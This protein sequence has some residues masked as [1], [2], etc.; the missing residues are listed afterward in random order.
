MKKG[1]YVYILESDS[2]ILYVGVTNDLERRVW[3]HKQKMA[4]GFTTKY[5]VHRLLYFEQFGEIERAIKREKQ[6]KK[7][8]RD[9]KLALIEDSNP[10]HEDLAA[11]WFE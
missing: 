4:P 11:H 6:I 2:G 7:W 8:R 3:E 5:K 1:G 9:K 10:V